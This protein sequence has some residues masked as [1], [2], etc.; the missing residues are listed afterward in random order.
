M[1]S[2]HEHHENPPVWLAALLH[3]HLVGRRWL[4]LPK[5]IAR[6]DAEDNRLETVP[7]PRRLTNDTANRGHVAIVE[8]P[9]QRVGQ[10]VFGK[11]L[12][13]LI[14]PGGQRLPQTFR[15]AD[16]RAIRQLTRRI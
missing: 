4:S 7:V 10:Q 16:F 2:G 9:T 15:S 8:A 12:D 14:G 13:E 5:R 11:C 6:D 3:S 1:L